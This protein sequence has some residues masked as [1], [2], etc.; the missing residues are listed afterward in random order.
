MCEF[1]YQYIVEPVYLCKAQFICGYIFKHHHISQS[2]YPYGAN[3]LPWLSEDIFVKVLLSAGE[4]ALQD[5]LVLLGQLFLYVPFGAP[6]DERLDHLQLK[7]KHKTKTKKYFIANAHLR[8][9]GEFEF[10]CGTSLI[11]REM[12][13]HYTHPVKADD[14][15]VAVVLILVCVCL[16]WEVR[17]GPCD[18]WKKEVDHSPQLLQSI[19]QRSVDEENPLLTGRYTEISHFN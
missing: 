10:E 8:T 19:L 5:V 16:N 18:S 11:S 13:M 15:F 1:Y 7:K 17:V 9:A 3:I 12:S 4:T 6:Q 14:Q 2:N